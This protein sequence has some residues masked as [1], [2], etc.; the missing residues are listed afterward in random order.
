MSAEH[1]VILALSEGVVPD[2]LAVRLFPLGRPLAAGRV[3]GDGAVLGDVEV[4]WSLGAIP[5]LVDES[6]TVKKVGNL[7]TE[8]P[9][10]RDM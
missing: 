8:N 4:R 5:I 2:Q 10:T 3:D 1:V 6:D 9:G 7:E